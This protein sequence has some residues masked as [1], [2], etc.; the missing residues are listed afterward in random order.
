MAV[1]FHFDL[2]LHDSNECSRFLIFSVSDTLHRHTAESSRWERHWTAEWSQSFAPEWKS[3]TNDPEMAVH[4]DKRTDPGR[5]HRSRIGCGCQAKV[6][7]SN[8][9]QRPRKKRLEARF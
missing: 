6:L 8:R 4:I 9:L 5:R 1:T 2:Q 7:E 3:A